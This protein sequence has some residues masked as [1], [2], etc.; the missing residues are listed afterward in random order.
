MMTA[1]PFMH[2]HLGWLWLPAQHL[3]RQGDAFDF[4][5]SIKYLQLLRLGY[6][7]ILY[8]IVG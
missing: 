1:L 6:H 5:I 3:L 2:W 7:V 8:L 4:R